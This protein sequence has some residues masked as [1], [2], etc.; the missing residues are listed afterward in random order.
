MNPML[1][2]AA[3]ALGYALCTG[4]AWAADSAAAPP[5][6]RAELSIAAAHRQGISSLTWSADGQ[7]IL[8]TS[9]DNSARLWDA[10]SG[11]LL[12]VFTATG[13]FVRGYSN[14]MLGAAFVDADR[15]LAIGAT[16]G[17]RLW[18][19]A[20]GRLLATLDGDTAMVSA[21]AA[22]PAAHLVATA[23]NGAPDKGARLFLRLH[24]PGAAARE[25]D[26]RGLHQIDALAFSP[27]GTRLALAAA[28]ITREGPG[29][30]EVAPAVRIIDPR[31]G[32]LLDD[33]KL[34]PGTASAV[35]FDGDARLLYQV[36]RQVFLRDL[37]SGRTAA[38]PA[39]AAAL[40]ADGAVLA[41]YSGEPSRS[42][43]NSEA[44]AAAL[45][46]V[47]GGQ[48]LE[49][50]PWAGAE[51]ERTV[52]QVSLY[53][54]SPDGQR[55]A[56]GFRD[57]KLAI[58][59]R[60]LHRYSSVWPARPYGPLHLA[61]T[62]RSGTRAVLP[63]PNGIAVWDLDKGRRLA[64]DIA[65][66]AEQI[67]ISPDG[68]QVAAGGSARLAMWDAAT[69]RQRWSAAG[70]IGGLAALAFHPSEDLL[71]TATYSS[72]YYWKASTGQLLQTRAAGLHSIAALAYSGDGRLLAIGDELGEVRLYPT[73]RGPRRYTIAA[74]GINATVT[75]LAFSADARRLAVTYGNG[76][77]RT[78]V[79][80]AGNGK[81]LHPA[82]AHAAAIT[83]LALGADDLLVTGGEDAI[84]RVW[85]GRTGV[86]RAG[87]A[88]SGAVQ[89][90]SLSADGRRLFTYADYSMRVW[91]L[92][93]PERP[94]AILRFDELPFRRWAVTDPEGRFDTGDLDTGGAL[95]WLMSDAPLRPLPPEIFMRDYFEPRLAARMLACSMARP[96]PA[97]ACQTAFP[98]RATVASLNRVRP[99]V[100]I[101][102][103]RPSSEPGY[104]LVRVVVTPGTDPTQTN[105]KTRSDGYDL[106]LFRDG[107]LVQRWPQH[108]DG[109]DDPG[110]W[111][112]RTHLAPR[113]GQ[114]RFEQEFSV[115]LPTTAHERPVEF[116]AYAFNDERVKS[117]TAR[118]ASLMLP[119]T[120]HRP[121]PKAYVLSVGI[122]GYA[123]PS[124]ALRF[125]V[126]DA[127]AMS[128]ALAGLEGYD[129]VSV[130]LA[131]E[132]VPA[133]W[134]ATKANIREALA[135][136]A[137]ADAVP[138]R[139][140]GVPQAGQLAR[141]GPDDLLVL[142]FSS[143]GYTAPDGSFYLLPSDS[144]PDQ[145][146]I[147]AAALPR[148][149]S[150]EELSAWLGPIDAGQVAMIIDACH[151]GAVVEQ[152]GFKPGPMGDRGLGQLAYDKGML[153]LAASQ[154]DD[155]A[156][157]SAHLRQGLLTYVLARDGL[158]PVSSTDPS[159]RADHDGDGQLTLAEWLRY[160]DQRTPGLYEDLRHGRL[161]IE[162]VGRDPDPGPDFYKKALR[163]AQTPA[164]FDF[165]R[166]RLTAVMSRLVEPPLPAGVTPLP[167][168]IIRQQIPYPERGP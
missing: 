106:H 18:N 122:N 24:R 146:K 138:G 99:V 21:L 110:A 7:R 121:R 30:V 111:R 55:L 44:S 23:G 47:A 166:G 148:F 112:L 52:N 81:P 22:S 85:D 135:R 147:E 137:G 58:W 119:A 86:Q 160:G 126:N 116:S 64:I 4:G 39:S 51:Y 1:R 143:H 48:L 108:P 75:G 123:A 149:I 12:R 151:A 35:R 78:L 54:F 153:I 36:D 46:S 144:G 130:V 69:G 115:R 11:A 2:R 92:S 43:D 97:A 95:H 53:A 27:D 117:A 118:D 42:A 159:L 71:A 165:T 133:S 73:R 129:V 77:N 127:R 38:Y 20:D 158:A 96:D 62:D 152:T 139:L 87:I 40:S 80:D 113:P 5:A 9:A 103:V 41:L 164:L 63:T 37:D 33:I 134:Q 17:T 49:R 14:R 167:K 10:G 157:E 29:S 45:Y 88:H 150:S 131:S 70:S 60:A 128:R 107:Q 74:P 145:G 141:A 61:L 72:V 79:Y 34:P 13:G 91:D 102:Q 15:Q 163:R 132:T 93:D 161:K 8:S 168:K 125:A 120:P 26:V 83:T 84:A 124:R 100:E 6:A 25:L 68:T 50:L 105:H 109:N 136:L 82:G 104:A 31:D 65:P 156:M 98:A 56:I 94:R 140:A 16:D 32:R 66:E 67:A 3:A 89:A 19:V 142:S 90:V 59:D 76:Y 154:G 28:A 114:A 57:G 101:T 162:Y 155:V